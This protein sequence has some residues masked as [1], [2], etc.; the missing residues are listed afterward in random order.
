MEVKT[1]R[2][3]NYGHNDGA[4]ILPLS[5]CDFLDYR[6]VVQAMSYLLSGTRLFERGPW[7]EDL[8]WLF[9]VAAL[10]APLN[11]VKQRKTSAH[12]GGYYTL[13]GSQS[14]AM[15]RCHSYFDRP[16]QADMLHLDLWFQEENLLRDT[17]SF[18]YYCAPVW[19]RYFKSSPAHNTVTVDDKDQMEIGPHFIWFNWVKSR[20]RHNQQLDEFD[21]DYWE[22]EHYGYCRD[23]EVVVHRRAIIRSQNRWL[24]I[25]DILGEGKHSATL[26]WHLPNSDWRSTLPDTICSQDLSAKITVQ[27]LTPVEMSFDLMR[28]SEHPEGWE[29]LYY[30]EKKPIPV[31]RCRAPKSPLPLRFMTGVCFDEHQF[32]LAAGL[33]RLQ[34]RLVAQLNDPALDCHRIAEITAALS[35]KC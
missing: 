35:A 16:G 14:W 22:G 15:I 7:D 33:V 13:R 21:G 9:G 8:V 17:G 34:G 23:K 26:H 28:G 30:G 19:Q 6:P 24:V 1:G 4:L 2:V 11:K 27:S 5:D 29:S 10:D 3:P 18:Q 32:E 12:L 20:L 25:D 31:L